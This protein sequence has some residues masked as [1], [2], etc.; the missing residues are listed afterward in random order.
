MSEKNY[1]IQR[2]RILEKLD[3]GKDVSNMEL[4]MYD[5]TPYFK[6]EN[7]DMNLYES[8]MI[9][10]N[11]SRRIEHIQGELY[12]SPPQYKALMTLYEKERVIISAPTSFGKTLLVKEYIYQKEP[13]NIVYIVPTNALAYELEK[14]FKENDNFSQYVI[15]DKC[16]S[17]DE[18]TEIP[19]RCEKLF[20][21]GTQEKFLE[22]DIAL[23]GEI[24]LFVIDEAYKLQDSVFNNQRAYKLSETFLDSIANNSKKIFLLTPKAS[25]VGFEKYEFYVFESDFNAVE[26][27]FTMLSESEFFSTLICKGSEDKTILFC[28]TPR[29]INDTYKEI[30]TRLTLSEPSDFVK[31]LE[32]DIHPDW[33]VVKLLRA[34]IL[35]HHGQM[36]KY[37]QNR[38]ISLFNENEKY[39]ML[40]GTNSISEGINTSTKNLF[41]YPNAA[42]RSDVLLIKNTIGRAGRLG[43]YP[44]GHIFSVENIEGTVENEITISL[45]ISSEEQLSEIEDSR[46]DERIG[47]SA[48]K[49]GIDPEFFG[50]LISNYKVSLSKLSKI[51]DALK[52]HRTFA[53]MTNLPFIALDAYGREYTTIAKNDVWL[54]KGY[55]QNYYKNGNERIF[56]NDFA[57]RIKFFKSKSKLNWDNTEIIN[58]YM[59]FIYSTLEYYIIPIVNIGI[60]L[61]D[62]IPDWGFG[63]NVLASLDDCK[64]KYYTKTYGNLN[65]DDLQEPHKL[66]ISAMKD[67][68]MNSIIK[69]LNIAILDEIVGQLNVRYSTSDVI[70]AINYLS[71]H[72]LENSSFFKEL[73]RKY[74]I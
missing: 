51:L 70:N 16:T 64:S 63:T 27:N 19:N 38:M 66:V 53:T 6:T 58:A 21:I 57:D 45:A 25:L 67:Y 73:K 65:V 9:T 8:I 55:L 10:K 44:I 49:Y 5:L 1:N 72:S 20:F 71:L 3:Q 37:V 69:N 11:Y 33:S 29:E 36:P 23:F 15:F 18:L 30:I 62:H 41:I 40:F 48:K 50:E 24:D 61:R 59:Q 34:N 28:K 12:F 32:E 46:N 74:F 2:K 68:G 56:L 54:M 39:N 31:R 4:G 7:F 35:T 22:V 13:K 14:S 42:N 17:I 26:K 47:E 60:D 52:K 43:K